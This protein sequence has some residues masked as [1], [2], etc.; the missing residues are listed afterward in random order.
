MKLVIQELRDEHQEILRLI[1]TRDFSALIDFVEKVHHPREELLLFPQIAALPMLK[2]GGPRCMYF[3]GLELDLDIYG[4]AKNLL[5]E[6]QTLG[7][8][9]PEPYSHYAWLNDNNPLNIPMYEHQLGH[10]LALAIRF[11]QSTTSPKWSETLRERL[12]EEYC[13][14][15]RLH[16]EKEE[17]CLFVMA[18]KTLVTD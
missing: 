18:E 14:L 12:Q 8:P 10:A 11:C 4:P 3:R 1:D 7:G 13:R 2:Q 5:K 15:L 16:I 17:T 6:Y 9:S